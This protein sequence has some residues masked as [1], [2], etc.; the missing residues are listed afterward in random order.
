MLALLALFE[1]IAVAVHFQDVD[2]V[3]QSIEQ[4]AG[5]PFGAEHGGPSNGRL[6][7]TIVEARS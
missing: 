5:Q 6:L 3:G 4:R 2:V 7:V 1:A